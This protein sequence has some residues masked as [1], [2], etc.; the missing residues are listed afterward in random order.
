MARD[1]NRWT[2]IGRLGADP[3]VRFLPSGDAVATIRIACADDYK[4]DGE[5]VERTEWVPLVIFGKG[6]ETAGK[7]LKK[8]SRIYAEGKFT[9]RKYQ[10]KEGKYRYST[11]IK[12]DNFQ[13]LDGKPSGGD[14]AERPARAAPQRQAAP[15]QSSGGGGGFID[16]DIPFAPRHWKEG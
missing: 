14:Q 8:G 3:E 9:T 13:M 1:L 12:V 4:K 11:E 10:D 2:G 15:A 7:Y 6:A 5:A 16:D